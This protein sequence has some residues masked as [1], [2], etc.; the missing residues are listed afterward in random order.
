MNK[1]ISKMYHLFSAGT[2][3]KNSTVFTYTP[4]TAQYILNT[5]KKNKYTL[6]TYDNDILVF[7]KENAVVKIFIDSYFNNYIGGTVENVS[8]SDIVNIL[9]Y[10]KTAKNAVEVDFYVFPFGKDK[11]ISRKLKYEENP[12]TF[13]AVDN[14]IEIKENWLTNNHDELPQDLYDDYANFLDLCKK[15]INSNELVSMKIPFESNKQYF[16]V[17]FPSNE[18]MIHG[19]WGARIQAEFYFGSTREFYI[20]NLRPV[21]TKYFQGCKFDSRNTESA[22]IIVYKTLKDFKN[23]MYLMMANNEINDLNLDVRKYSDFDNDLITYDI[24]S[25]SENIQLL[26]KQEIESIAEKY[27]LVWCY[28]VTDTLV[29]FST[30]RSKGKHVKI[31]IAKSK[32]MIENANKTGVITQ[33]LEEIQ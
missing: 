6:K 30:Y 20:N 7:E 27:N 3:Y 31:C 12:K 15:F 28:I 25:I 29:G 10:A 11:E 14:N 8:S 23:S 19:K 4:N 32:Q 33:N 26:R 13:N 17:I 18:D 5:L 2:G 1:A 9:K 24:G 21:V 16:K 22:V